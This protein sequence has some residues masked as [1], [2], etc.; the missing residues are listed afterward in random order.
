MINPS[1]PVLIPT[2]HPGALVVQGVRESLSTRETGDWQFGE[3]AWV[4]AVIFDRV[5]WKERGR[6][7]TFDHVWW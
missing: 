6:E 3:S 5:G 2:R 7:G 4:Q 1:L